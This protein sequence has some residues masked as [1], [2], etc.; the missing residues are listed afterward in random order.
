MGIS[1]NS[2]PDYRG[3]LV[4]H[5]QKGIQRFIDA[6]AMLENDSEKVALASDLFGREGVDIIAALKSVDLM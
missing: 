3:I 6:A 2:P 4:R 5:G 1:T